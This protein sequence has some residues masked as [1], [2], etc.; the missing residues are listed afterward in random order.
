MSGRDP[1]ATGFSDPNDGIQG[2]HRGRYLFETVAEVQDYATKWLWSYNHERSNLA[3]G[4]ILRNNDRP[5]WPSLYFQR[6][7]EMG[8]IPKENPY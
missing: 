1:N 6:P 5:S 4:G 3:L 2:I 8:G 7:L